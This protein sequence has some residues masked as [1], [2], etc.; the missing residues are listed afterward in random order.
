M[1]NYIF[2]K[3][4]PI[5]EA[6]RIIRTIKDNKLDELEQFKGQSV[7]I[8]ILPDVSVVEKHKNNVNMINDLKGSCPNLPDGMEFQEKI[9]KEWDR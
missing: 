2:L 1:A 8:I 4:A 9:R 6:L 3:E 5:M 7:E